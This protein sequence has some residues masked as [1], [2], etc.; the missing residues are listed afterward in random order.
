M[1]QRAA[2]STLAFSLAVLMGTVCAD[3][4]DDLRSSVCNAG[5]VDG[6]G[7]C[8][9]MIADRTSSPGVVYVVS[10]KTQAVLLTLRPRV[11]T[12]GLAGAMDRL[13]DVNGDGTSDLVVCWR[14]DATGH[15]RVYSGDD[16]REL[17]VFPDSWTAAP[18]GDVDADGTPDLLLGASHFWRVE[19][20]ARVQ[21]RSGR[22]G[23]LLLEK[24]GRKPPKDAAFGGAGVDGADLFGASFAGLGDIDGDGHGDFAVGSPG[25]SDLLHP[26]PGAVEVFSGRDGHSIA[27]VTGRDESYDNLG[28]SMVA[29]GDVDADGKCDLLVGAINRYVAVLSG[30]DLHHIRADYSW[31]YGWGWDAFGSSVDR[32]GDVDGDG[33]TDWIAAANDNKYGHGGYAEVYSS[34]SGEVMR[35]EFECKRV[36]VDVCGIGDVNSDHVPDEVIACPKNGWVRLRSGK[37]GT[38]IHEIRISQ[39]RRAAQKTR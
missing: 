16:G 30:L 8:D 23:S 12:E 7:T 26:S 25:M 22:D 18:A 2:A 39:M 13:G 10:G 34:R 28:W 37:D 9:L 11:V 35:L 20:A 24:F 31:A 36:G 27:R 21:V 32:L 1:N 15:A 38:L 5:D 3:D 17:F 14:A 33:I 29:L 4:S 19:K 6:D